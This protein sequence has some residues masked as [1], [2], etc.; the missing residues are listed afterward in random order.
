MLF[1]GPFIE[2]DG[3]IGYNELCQ[4]KRDDGPGK[5][6]DVWDPV[7]EARYSYSGRR[8]VSYDDEETLQRKVIFSCRQGF[9]GMMVWAIDLD[10]DKG[11]L[12]GRGRFPLL[13]EINRALAQDCEEYKDTPKDDKLDSKT[14]VKL[15][16][17]DA[18]RNSKDVEHNLVDT[19]PSHWNHNKRVVCYWE[20]WAAERYGEAKFDID[21]IDTGL[22][23]NVVY[24]F[25]GIQDCELKIIDSN[26]AFKFGK[27]MLRR[28]ANLK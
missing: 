14:A 27:D 25:A 23:T 7:A 18:V 11:S 17:K 26:V 8:W 28:A 13:K 5:W 19:P 24:A 9:A 1:Q 20:S 10:D 6:T 16:S 21:E 2:E 3:L 4:L 12:C 15:D 22:C